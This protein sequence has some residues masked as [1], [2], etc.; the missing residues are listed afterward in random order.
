MLI[1]MI[2]D[3]IKIFIQCFNLRI[4]G[5]CQHLT[6]Y[7]EGALVNIRVRVIFTNHIGERKEIDFPVLCL[8]LIKV[9]TI[10]TLYIRA[11]LLNQL[12]QIDKS[13]GIQNLINSRIRNN[14]IG[15]L[16]RC[17]HCTDFGIQI[18]Y[19]KLQLKVHACLVL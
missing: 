19:Q 1:H 10:Y 11:V 9:R 13:P 15:I 16:I 3:Q 5:F 8:H 14:N 6:L 12:R 7:P 2:F 18:A 4:A 17:N